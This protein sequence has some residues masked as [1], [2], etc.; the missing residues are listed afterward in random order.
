[1]LRFLQQQSIISDIYI[2]ELHVR[3]EYVVNT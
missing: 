1:M 2:Y 3:N